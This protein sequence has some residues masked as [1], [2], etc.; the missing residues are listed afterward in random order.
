MKL[1]IIIEENGQEAKWK[2]A[3]KV[4]LSPEFAYIIPICPIMSI[5]DGLSQ[6]E[7]TKMMDEKYCHNDCDVH[8]LHL[9]LECQNDLFCSFTDDEQ[10]M[11]M[12]TDMIERMFI[13]KHQL[14]LKSQLGLDEEGFAEK[15][16]KEWKEKSK[17]GVE[18]K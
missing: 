3:T 8:Q 14:E 9:E 7:H 17:K 5:K 12:I 16:E 13:G 6:E 1:Q 2:Y 15:S 18:E 4:Y 10:A 11:A